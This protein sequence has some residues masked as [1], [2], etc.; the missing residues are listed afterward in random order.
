MNF[1]LCPPPTQVHGACGM[2]GCI[3]AALF[4]FTASIVSTDASDAPAREPLLKSSAQQNADPEKANAV[5]QPPMLT[6]A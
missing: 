2:W 5:G 3:A 1:L 4:L 6:K